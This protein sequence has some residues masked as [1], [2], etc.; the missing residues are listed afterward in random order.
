M[1]LILN[2]DGA[3]GVAFNWRPVFSAYIT[4]QQGKKH[5]PL[6]LLALYLLKSIPSRLHIHQCL[7][8]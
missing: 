2:S 8:T 7:T 3:A 1:M 6:L 4:A 5:S